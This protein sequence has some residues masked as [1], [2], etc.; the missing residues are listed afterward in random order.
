MSPGPG[1]YNLSS[2]TDKFKPSMYKL[3][4]KTQDKRSSRSP[5]SVQPT[6]R[7]CSLAKPMTGGVFDPMGVVTKKKTVGFNYPPLK[8]TKF[9]QTGNT[10]FYKTDGFKNHKG[11]KFTNSPENLRN[12][13]AVS[14]D[15]H[16]KL[17]EMGTNSHTSSISK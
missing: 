3:T 16:Q 11:S 10:L 17:P 6:P 8:P 7:D 2:F 12:S 1:E 13:E 4:R 15:N 14:Y 5:R 9:F